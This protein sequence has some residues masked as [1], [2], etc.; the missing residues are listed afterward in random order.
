MPLG[1]TVLSVLL[2]PFPQ[3]KPVVPASSNSQGSEELQA[4]PR[5]SLPTQVFPLLFFAVCT[6]HR[7]HCLAEGSHQYFCYQDKE[8]R[9][10]SLCFSHLRVQPR[11][12]APC[13]L[14]HVTPR[15]SFCMRPPNSSACK[16]AGGHPFALECSLKVECC[17]SVVELAS[18]SLCQE[19]SSWHAPNRAVQMNP[20]LQTH[21]IIYVEITFPPA[22]HQCC[23]LHTD[24]S[25]LFIRSLAEGTVPHVKYSMV[26]ADK[27]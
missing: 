4:T 9:A 15:C 13:L 22:T 26:D 7:T 12:A 2:T 10:F 27:I 25:E 6:A 24:A 3:A 23:S 21:I 19:E 11:V 5:L 16:A 17:Y 8:K 1:C 18:K 14:S 20:A